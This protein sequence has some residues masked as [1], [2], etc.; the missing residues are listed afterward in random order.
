MIDVSSVRSPAADPARAGETLIARFTGRSVEPL[1]AAS[2]PDCVDLL[3]ARLNPVHACSIA[4]HLFGVLPLIDTF[5]ESS[6]SRLAAVAAGTALGTLGLFTPTP[7][8]GWGAAAIVGEHHDRALRVW[9]EV[10]VASYTADG[11]IVLVRLGDGDQRLVWLDHQS[12]GVMLRGSRTGGPS[13]RRAPRWLLVEGATIVDAHVS[14]PVMLVPGQ[15]LYGRLEQWAAI[16]SL[17]AL[18]YTRATVRRL[19]Q[20]VRTTRRRGHAEPFSASQL[21]TMDLAELE[22]E[23]EL[24]LIAARHHFTREATHPSGLLLA[25][26]A[27]QLRDDLGLSIDGALT[28]D[29]A[30]ALLA[31]HVGGTLGLEHELALA[32]DL[33]CG[34]AGGLS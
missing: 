10:R 2:V 21:V 34:S 17:V 23:T 19:R 7:D 3:T 15:E 9:G 13:S 24:T 32:L 18:E 26:S 28:D 14:R 16:W 12:T 30:S 1:A 4:E 27:A 6:D 33:G 8:G 31:A 22:I 29:G 25:L 5:F 20:A 11:S